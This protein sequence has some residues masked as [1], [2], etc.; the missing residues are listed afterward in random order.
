MTA[1]CSSL[2]PFCYLSSPFELCPRQL[3]IA[4]PRNA[5]GFLAP[6]RGRTGSGRMDCVQ[7]DPNG[8]P[9]G[10]LGRATWAFQVG[11]VQHHG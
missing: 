7:T 3:P 4:V 11:E 5:W 8:L 10:V 2:L 1:P 9:I 6:V